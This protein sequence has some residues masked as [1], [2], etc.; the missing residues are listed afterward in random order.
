MSAAQRSA[1][2]PFVIQLARRYFEDSRDSAELD[3]V[4]RRLWENGAKYELPR[5]EQWLRR[6]A[7]DITAK[8]TA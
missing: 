7:P 3:P 8:L 6:V 4:F 1:F 5:A 2:A